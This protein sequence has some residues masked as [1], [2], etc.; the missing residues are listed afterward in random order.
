VLGIGRDIPPPQHGETLLDRKPA[1]AG[2]EFRPLL[3]VQGQERHA[4]GVPSDGRQLEP[5]HRAQ[6]RVGD[7]R[8]DPCAVAGARI[9]PH[10][11]A[12]LEV[13]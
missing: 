5:G 12:V 4:D 6:E 7:L 10:R 13:A 9:R 2:L 1:D 11:A 3:L 8:D